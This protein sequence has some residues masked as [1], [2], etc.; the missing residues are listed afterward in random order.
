M[1]PTIMGRLSAL[2]VIAALAASYYR[3]ATSDPARDAD[4]SSSS[5]Y[6]I[7]GVPSDADKPTI[8]KAYRAL[9]RRWHPDRNPDKAAA[10]AAFATI[11]H[12]Y[13]VLADPEKRE[14]FNRLGDQGL[15]RFRDGDPSVRKDWLPPDEVLR[16]IHSDGDEPFSAWVVTSSF[17]TLSW[18]LGSISQLV[19]P[20]GTALG[21]HSD[22]PL[23]VI[24]ATES[25]SGATVRSG[26]RTA[27]AVTFKFA[28]SGKSFDFDVRDVAHTCA[29]PTKFLGM[30][31]AFYLQC[32]H[33]AGRSVRVS[34]GA[35]VF[36]VTGRV[37]GNAASE[38]FELTML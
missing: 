24:T 29:E 6:A 17:A 3:F 35:N 23:V 2:A 32:A 15:E 13:D 12:A 26:G 38:V 8:V 1:A 10:D 33:A 5:P 31:T 14:I 25:A 22:F 9:A 18:L 7:L 34:V 28:L 19:L 11:S 30:K 37:K 21:V 27:E 20:L 16:R 36:T 4:V